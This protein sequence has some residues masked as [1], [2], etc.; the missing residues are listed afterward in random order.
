MATTAAD[1]KPG[2]PCDWVPFPPKP[3]I[4]A[5]LSTLPRQ[6]A[7][8]PEYR[9]EM[10]GRIRGHRL[11][12]DPGA[13]PPLA[14]WRARE[15]D[16]PGIMLLEMWAYVLDVLGFY[17]ERIANETYLRTAVR[18]ASLRRLVELIGYHPRPAL[19]A[20][21]TLAL[22]AEEGNGPV[23]VPAGTAFRSAA[24]G[25]E[26]PH[27]FET[28]VPAR[29]DP[30]RNEWTLAPIRDRVIKDDYFLN[31]DE[32]AVERGDLVLIRWG[33]QRD[34]ARMT[35][36]HIKELTTQNALDGNT[37][38]KVEFN[39]DVSPGTGGARVGKATL[40]KATRTATADAESTVLVTIRPVLRLR[41]RPLFPPL[42]PLPE[43]G[44]L[45]S[46]SWLRFESTQDELEPGQLVIVTRGA[47]KRHHARIGDVK[48]IPVEQN[49]QAF[50]ETDFDPPSVPVTRIR[51]HPPLPDGWENGDLR[52]HFGLVEAGRLTRPA[53]HRVRLSDLEPSASFEGVSEPLEEGA[54]PNGLLL[55]GADGIGAGLA[56]TAKV[57]PAGSG[58]LEPAQ[59][60]AG[61]RHA[62]R[63]PVRAFGN[64]VEATR[65]ESVVNEVLG[66][67]DASIAFQKFALGKDPLTYVR[68]P[69]APDGRR[70]TL[71]V[72]V[73]GLLWREV[74]SFFGAGPDAEV[75]TVRRHPETGRSIVTF[76]DGK[77]GAR[78]PTGVDN[79]VASYRFGAG[80][81]APPANSIT[82]LARPVAGIRSVEN[83]VPAGGGA[84]GDRPKDL[85]R[86]APDSALLLGRAVSLRDFEALAREFGVVNARAD[87][88]WDGRTQRAVVKILFIPSS[89]AAAEA[90]ERELRATLLGQADPNTPLVARQASPVPA[91]LVVDL[92]PGPRRNPEDVERAVAHALTDPE[93]GLLAL[94]NVP[95]GRPLFRSAVFEQILSV[96]GAESVR[97]L[98]FNGQPFGASRNPGE[99]RYFSFLPDLRVGSTAAGD[100]LFAEAAATN[101]SNAA[102]F[103]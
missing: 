60:A 35:T 54:Q 88:T 20:R 41:G 87:W 93:T 89:D 70:S 85:R 57:D 45:T 17:D 8:F 39:E 50:E 25:D 101:A 62:L 65:G 64:R 40:L 82:Q 30:R 96:E 19:A 94:E 26:P 44:F 78:L 46:N 76:G 10:L 28:T 83:P 56:G 48:E 99:G 18:P 12:D 58:R 13:G 33:D 43:P 91:E 59:G 103:R 14:D 97:G 24:F 42:E 4:P 71:Q 72:R 16:D 31:P 3:H 81:A 6:L 69:A 22:L 52:V 47:S 51:I 7:G 92:V 49:P 15:G 66:S 5:G 53:R 73:N 75:Y 67:G 21:V 36:A 100:E 55:L 37:Y 9:L 11:L 98:S 84:D 95:I 80:A 102:A 79:V 74:T 34:T 38:L 68:D 77:T 29:I 27:V 23:A 61:F 32:A 86:S 2:C 90:N 1:D 63:T